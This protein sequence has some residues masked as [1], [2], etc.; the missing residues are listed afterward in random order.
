MSPVA[1]SK[2]PQLPN[3]EIVHLCW[4]QGKWVSWAPD[5]AGGLMYRD[6]FEDFDPRRPGNNALPSLGLLAEAQAKG[7]VVRCILVSGSKRT[8][9]R[10][11]ARLNLVGHVTMAIAQPGQGIEIIFRLG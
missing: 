7:T 10:Y 1:S 4:Q 9:T 3:G 11:V 8:G 5:G 6:K 2:F